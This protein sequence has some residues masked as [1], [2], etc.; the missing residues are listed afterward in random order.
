MVNRNKMNPL[1]PWLISAYKN[2]ISL[3]NIRYFHYV[4]LIHSLP[5]IGDSLLVQNIVQWFMCKKKNTMS[6]QKCYS[7]E[8]VI[9]KNHPD[10][11][12][13]NKIPIGIDDIR[14]VT[15]KINNFSQQNGEKIVYINIDKLTEFASHALLKTLEEPPKNSW[16]FLKTYNPKILLPT[17]KSR[18]IKLSLSSPTEKI[19]LLWLLKNTLNNTISEKECL[20]ALRIC[21]NAPISALNLINNQWKLR[22]LFLKSFK[23]SLKKNFFYLLP[24]INNENILIYIKWMCSIFM[25]AIKLHH[26]LTKFMTNIDQCDLISEITKKFS[27]FKLDTILKNFFIFHND[28]MKC[29]LSCNRE[30]IIVEQLLFLEK[31]KNYLN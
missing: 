22:Y 19:G 12:Y 29:K 18:C 30:L 2:I 13:L 20:I 5:G 10:V 3:Y 26:K 9:S 17:L 25:D 16:F 24:T 21:N 27:L 1:Y 23:A 15:N 7:C 4:L 14:Y 8:L 11:Y 31:I 28:L 6:C